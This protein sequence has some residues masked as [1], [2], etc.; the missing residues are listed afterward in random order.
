MK[1]IGHWVE[2]SR[3][4]EERKK[5]YATRTNFDS[6]D[7]RGRSVVVGEQFYPYAK[8]HQVDPKRSGGDCRGALAAECVW[9]ISFPREYTRR[10]VDALR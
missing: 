1:Q 2:V 8:Q 10:D 3:E 6:P 9:T 5:E 4:M 7:R